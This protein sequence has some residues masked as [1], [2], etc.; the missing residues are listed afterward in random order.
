MF[1]HD[2]ETSPEPADIPEAPED[3]DFAVLL[4]ADA[5]AADGAELDEHEPGYVETDDHVEDDLVYL[6]DDGEEVTRP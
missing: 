3:L 1:E 2:P 4:D 5:A 6:D